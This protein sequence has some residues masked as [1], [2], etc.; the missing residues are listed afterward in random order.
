M[1][2]LAPLK[3][4]HKNK[5]ERKSKNVSFERSPE[6]EIRSEDLDHTQHAQ[7]ETERK[8]MVKAH[9]SWKWRMAKSRNCPNQKIAF[10]LQLNHQFQNL[11]G[12]L[13]KSN[14]VPSHSPSAEAAETSVTHGKGKET[15]GR[16][17]LGWAKQNCT[18]NT[19][20]SSVYRLSSLP[21]HC[22]KNTAGRWVLCSVTT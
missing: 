2:D 20:G 9:Q 7:W 15:T 8:Q 14:S 22:L 12:N 17:E 10:H 19:L 4:Q 6:S 13:L 21:L 3:E 1:K 16:L 18:E 11:R 5:W